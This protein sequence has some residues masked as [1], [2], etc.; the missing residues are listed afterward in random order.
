MY[1]NEMGSILHIHN[2]LHN[3][4][5]KSC[6][7]RGESSCLFGDLADFSFFDSIFIHFQ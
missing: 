5:V 1:S 7:N 6:K 4:S 2:I 3:V